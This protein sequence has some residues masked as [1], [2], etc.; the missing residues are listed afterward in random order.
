[1]PKN[2]FL[3]RL[4]KVF[5]S[6]KESNSIIMGDFNINMKEDDSL[7]TVAGKEGF[8]PIVNCGTTIHGSLLDQ[9]FINFHTSSV[10]SLT[11][12]QRLSMNKSINFKEWSS[13]DSHP[14]LTNAM[15]RIRSRDEE[16]DFVIILE[17]INPKS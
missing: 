10:L 6:H 11:R 1:M 12:N 7:K 13:H 16:S 4:R 15:A 2:D 9:I 8:Y 17:S 3:E 14:L 5:R